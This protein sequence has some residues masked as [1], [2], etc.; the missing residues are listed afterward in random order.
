MDQLPQWTYCLTS[1]VT[2]LAQRNFVEPRKQQPLIAG[3]LTLQ[4]SS[5]EGFYCTEGRREGV[6][7]QVPR[8]NINKSLHGTGAN[9]MRKTGVCSRARPRSHSNMP[10]HEHAH[11]SLL[12]FSPTRI[13]HVS[14]PLLVSVN[15]LKC[16]ALSL[17]AHFHF[18]VNMQV[19]S[20]T[21]M[22]YMVDSDDTPSVNR[23]LIELILGE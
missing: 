2:K 16:E 4:T 12:N 3:M 18:I 13:A 14:Q 15:S 6:N 23:R 21:L 5:A 8:V 22:I 11:D 10:S 7:N 1:C 20:V 9:T 17:H 19:L